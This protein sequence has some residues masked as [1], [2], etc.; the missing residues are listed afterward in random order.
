[1]VVGVT[2]FIIAVLIIAIWVI[3]EVKRL[4]HKIFAVALIALILFSYLSAAIIFRGSDVNSKSPSG[5]MD[6]GKIYFAWIGSVVGN[7]AK[8]TTNAIKMDWGTSSDVEKSVDDKVD[9]VSG[10]LE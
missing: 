9:K 7:F 10:Y 2:L 4:K 1:M 6:A 8:L 5:I 3:I